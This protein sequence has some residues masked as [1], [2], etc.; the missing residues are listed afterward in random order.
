MAR[1]LLILSLLCL[2]TGNLGMPIDMPSQKEAPYSTQ[3]F[4]YLSSIKSQI[5][6]SISVKEVPHKYETFANKALYYGFNTAKV[7]AALGIFCLAVTVTERIARW[8]YRAIRGSIQYWRDEIK[9]LKNGGMDPDQLALEK[10]EFV[11]EKGG[12]ESPVLEKRSQHIEWSS[13]D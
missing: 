10:D 13:I 6:D 1:F 9:D 7:G 3:L 8:A 4:A 5:E 2:I 12:W 11:N